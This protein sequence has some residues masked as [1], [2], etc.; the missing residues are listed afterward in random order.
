MHH[1]YCTILN[2]SNKSWDTVFIFCQDNTLSHLRLTTSCEELLPD[3]VHN[4]AEMA[5]NPYILSECDI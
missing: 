5:Q 3:L 2:I 1:F 4:N